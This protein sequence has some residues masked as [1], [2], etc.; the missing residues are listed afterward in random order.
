MLSAAAFGP[1]FSNLCLEFYRLFM[2]DMGKLRLSNRKFATYLVSEMQKDFGTTPSSSL[3]ALLT[4][5]EVDSKETREDGKKE[6]QKERQRDRETE[7][8]T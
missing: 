7:R 6:R 1:F 3:A 8:E 4:G 2:V 5:D